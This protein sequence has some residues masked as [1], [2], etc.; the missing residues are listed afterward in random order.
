[1]VVLGWGSLALGQAQTK[2]L[3]VEESVAIAWKQSPLVKAAGFAREA[4]QALADHEKPVV[5]PK[6]EIV[7]SRTVQGP[8]VTFPRSGGADATVG[9][10]APRG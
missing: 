9:W 4:G 8:R 3:T 1:M 2:P 5:R 6:V 7:A 10:K